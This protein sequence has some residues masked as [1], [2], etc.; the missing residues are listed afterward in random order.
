LGVRV[1]A[2]NSSPLSP[3]SRRP[4]SCAQLGRIARHGHCGLLHLTCCQSSSMGTRST[5]ASRILINKQLNNCRIA[6]LS[7]VK[8]LSTMQYTPTKLVYTTAA[9]PVPI[10]TSRHFSMPTIQTASG[11]N[12]LPC[13]QS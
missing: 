8:Q 12:L 9:R 3:Y 4:S 6:M 11:R 10:R 1:E 13:I 5:S 2:D 7:H